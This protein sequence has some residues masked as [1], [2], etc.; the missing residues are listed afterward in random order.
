MG[1]EMC[2][3]DGYRPDTDDEKVVDNGC[4]APWVPNMEAFKNHIRDDISNNSDL[5]RVDASKIVIAPDG[6]GVYYVENLVGSLYDGS[7]QDWIDN[8][9]DIPHTY[10]SD[11]IKGVVIDIT[12]GA[13]EY[14][15]G[16]GLESGGKITL[17]L[18]RLFE[19]PQVTTA[20]DFTFRCDISKN[21][22]ESQDGEGWVEW[23]DDPGDEGRGV[24]CHLYT[25]D[26]DDE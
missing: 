3:R 17:Q 12:D 26:A 7:D 11:Q 19:Y 18:D 10:G 5:N 6:D 13:L 9:I 14:P 4:C 2:I 1:S 15:D 8:A 22:I 25:S 21:A 24:A 16:H 23:V 20:A